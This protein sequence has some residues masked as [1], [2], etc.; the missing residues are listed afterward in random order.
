VAGAPGPE[1]AAVP[2]AALREAEVV[3]VLLPEPADAE[4]PGAAAVVAVERLAAGR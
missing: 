1:G 3:V 4:A 2:A